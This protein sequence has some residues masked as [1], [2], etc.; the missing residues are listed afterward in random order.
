MPAFL[1]V[2]LSAAIP[3]NAAVLWGVRGGFTDG[4]AMFGADVAIPIGHGFVFNPGVEVSKDL[5]STNADFHY[6]VSIS[7]DAAFWVGAGA[8]LINPEG[9]D[10]DGGVNL[11]VGL[12]TRRGRAILYTQAKATRPSSY[13]SYTTFAVGIRF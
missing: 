8:A 12:A 10:L 7:R 11:L 13:D 2:L 1:F 4:Q 3:L 6:D 9:Q 5:I